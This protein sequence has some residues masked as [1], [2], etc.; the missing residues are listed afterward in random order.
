LEFGMLAQSLTSSLADAADAAISGV[1]RNGGARTPRPTGEVTAVRTM[2]LDGFDEIAVRWSPILKSA[3]YCI[4]LRTVFC[5]SR[6]HVTFAPVPH[7]K[8]PGGKIP[9]RCELADL[10]IVIDHIDP[11]QGIDDRRAVLIQAKLLKGRAIKP[12]GAEWVQHELLG[13]LPTFTFVDAS[14]DKR[15]RDFS[16]YPLLGSPVHSAEYGGIDLK[17]QPPVWRQ[18]LTQNT[19]PWFNSPIALA[20]YL[21]KMATGCHGCSRE[22]ARGGLDDWSFTVD[23][24]LNVTGARPITK[25]DSV[26]VRGNDNLVGFVSDTSPVSS[27]GDGGWIGFTEGGEPDWPQGPIST[28]HTVIRSLNDRT[29]E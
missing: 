2:T 18:E 20:N 12:S 23:E 7:P 11:I 22:A 8:H 19:A 4:S 9:R 16:G 27:S 17:A 14:Y 29:E 28:V 25:K 10:L 21:A 1:L 13:W 5:H 24:L 26:F 15:R 6:P 3:G